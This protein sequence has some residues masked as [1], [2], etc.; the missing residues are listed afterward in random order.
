MFCWGHELL[1]LILCV[2]G[3]LRNDGFLLGCDDAYS[4]R[5]GDARIS[6][7]FYYS[8]SCKHVYWAKN[9]KKSHFC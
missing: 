2:D 1:I 9:K 8:G 7:I 4:K 6:V 3:F 5:G